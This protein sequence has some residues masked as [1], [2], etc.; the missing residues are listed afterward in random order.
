M[1][2]IRTVMRAS[3]FSSVSDAALA[4]KVVLAKANRARLL[5]M[6][7]GTRYSS[8]VRFRS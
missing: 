3:D 6:M 8:N 4:R 5:V 1:A 2:K 7:F